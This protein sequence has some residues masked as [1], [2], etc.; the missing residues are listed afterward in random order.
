MSHMLN[1]PMILLR[2]GADCSQ[3]KAQLLSN[4]TACNAVVDV[5][6]T[7]LG[8]RGMDKLIDNGGGDV[9]ITN[10]GATLMALL[11]VIHPA[12]KLML[13]IAKAQDEEVGDGTTSVVLIAGEFLSEAKGFVEDGLHPQ[14]IIRGYRRACAMAIEKIQQIQVDLSSKSPEARAQLLQKCAETSLNSKLLSG[15]KSFFGKMAVDAVGMLGENRDKEMIGIKQVTGGSCTDSMLIDGVAFKKTFS[16]AGFEQQPKKFTDPKILMLN[17]ELELKAEKENAEIRLTDPDEYH[18]IVEAEWSIIYDK[19]DSIVKSGA[20]VV[21]SR[22][23]IGDLATQY[24]ADRGVFCAGRVEESDV[25]RTCRSTGAMV[26]TTASRITQEVLGSCGE[27][28]EIQIGK[29]RYNLFRHCPKTRSSTIILRG[30]ASQFIEEASRSLNDAIMIVLRAATSNTIV[31]GGGAIEM[32]LSRHLRQESRMVAGKEQ[33]VMNQFA[34]ALECIPKALAHNAGLDATDLLNALRHKHANAKPEN[35]WF[36][37]DCFNG[38]VVDAYEQFI[39][40]PSIV[41]INAISAATE[42]ACLLLSIDETIKN[43]RSEQEGGG[44]GGRG[45]MPMPRGGMG[46]MRGMRGRGGR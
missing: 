11:N 29:E 9:T 26:Q 19:L 40:E 35:R 36:G 42:A 27:F 41:K 28:E 24:F 5:I 33:L 1:A 34:K 25:Q 32:E 20:Q 44:G 4:I 3:G 15:Y 13:D 16:Y 30:G 31:G 7:T 38:G 12:A 37:V 43:P 21:L 22:L 23:P 46:G 10:D 45:R 18:S 6:R 39:W 14:V 17:I 2:E 8:P